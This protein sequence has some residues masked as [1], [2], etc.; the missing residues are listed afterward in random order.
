MIYCGRGK[1]PWKRDKIYQAERERKER[2]SARER[3]EGSGWREE[4]EEEEEEEADMSYFLPLLGCAVCASSSS[5]LPISLPPSFSL[6][7]HEIRARSNYFSFQSRRRSSPFFFLPDFLEPAA[8][9]FFFCSFL[10]P[11]F[12]ILFSFFPPPLIS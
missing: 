2:K 12:S 4:E 9:L 7:F 6:S 11:I 8:T 5:S 10:P 3:K 1:F